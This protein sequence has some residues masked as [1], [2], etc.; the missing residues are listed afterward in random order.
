MTY[1]QPA[2]DAYHLRWGY[3]SVGDEPELI[4][5]RP[6]KPIP[7]FYRLATRAAET[8]ISRRLSESKRDACVADLKISIRNHTGRIGTVET[9]IQSLEKEPV[10][11][12]ALI[13]LCNRYLTEKYRFR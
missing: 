12:R 8:C 3:F 4:G 2:M 13:G 7:E 6:N 9:P 5:V 1:S 10:E 11:I